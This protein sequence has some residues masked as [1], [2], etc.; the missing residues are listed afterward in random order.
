MKIEKSKVFNDVIIFTPDIF[1][2]ER[3]IFFEAYNVEKYFNTCVE[4]DIDFAVKGN[5]EINSW[6]LPQ[7]NVSISDK[8]VF[9]GLHYQKRTHAQ[10]KLAQ[11]IKGYALDITVDLRVESSTYSQFDIIKL[12]DKERKQLYIPPGFAHGFLS[13]KPNTTF[14]YHCTNYYHKESEM[15]LSIF[16]NEELINRLKGK[17]RGEFILSEKDLKG[18]TLRE[19]ENNGDL[20]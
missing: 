11:V 19:L 12:D 17:I 2:D 7:T 16:D 3:G 13:M 8:N 5:G 15:T 14:H 1:K 18:F 20:F 9:R 6:V 4:T 10:G